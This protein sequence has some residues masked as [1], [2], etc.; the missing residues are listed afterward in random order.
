MNQVTDPGETNPGEYFLSQ[1]S[2]TDVVQ[3][4]N[5]C[6][7]YPHDPLETI[8]QVDVVTPAGQA[9]DD[10]AGSPPPAE[11]PHA[12]TKF[13]S[14]LK[15]AHATGKLS[16]AVYD[17]SVRYPQAMLSIGAG[18]CG[19][20]PGEEVDAA[21]ARAQVATLLKDQAVNATAADVVTVTAIS[22]A[23]CPP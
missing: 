18:V 4:D 9:D 15:T 7:S 6:Q 20:G 23:T 12:A 14:S 8:L 1:N 22:L 3:F 11:Q 17:W 10:G 5:D 19:D 21:T 13:A 16:A 2:V